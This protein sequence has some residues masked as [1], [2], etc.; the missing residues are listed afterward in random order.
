[1]DGPLDRFSIPE[2]VT[3]IT[4]LAGHLNAGN[5]HFLA[6]IAELDRRR[7]W[8]EWGVKSCAHWLNWKCG[9]NLGAAREKLRAAHALEQLPKI[10]AAMASGRI[11]YAKVRAMTRTAD[12]S[13]E[14]YLLSIALHGTAQHVERTVRSYR[15]AKESQEH[16][17]EA[18]QHL[19]QNL[20][21]FTQPDGSILIRGRVPAEIGE[22]LRRALQLAE[23]S[24]PIPKNVSAETF[25]EEDRRRRARRPVEAL[26][27][28]AESFLAH[29]PQDV[30]G[31]DRQQIVIHVDAQTLKHDHEGRCEFEHGPSMAAETA[32]R[33]ACDASLITMIEN[34]EGE[35]LNVGRK[36]RTIPPGIRRALNS[37]DK[38]C[39]FPGCTFQRYVD[40][41]HIKHWVH[42]GETKLSNLVMLCRFHHRLVHEG[43]VEVQMLDDGAVRF[44][45]PGGIAYDS[46]LPG[47]TRHATVA[48]LMAAN[49]AR[50]I[51]I[52]RRTA[53]PYMTDTGMDY[54][55]AVD[56]LLS[57]NARQ[58]NVSAET[59]AGNPG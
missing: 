28:L 53:I 34:E 30:S 25:S 24:L 39:R 58:K 37:R 31:A 26:G 57:R 38:D 48:K 20:W 41:H 5:A 1:M 4:E 22:L 27:L 16:S 33:P 9:L 12:L 13:N 7:G 59:C 36:T 43:K 19:N 15:R 49:E 32:R 29:G 6:L 8:A 23:D 45:R 2:L 40:G 11:S 50:G 42:G 47:E 55:L 52:T 44:V 56:L 14:D 51:E 35:P 46:P 21:L 18:Q 54:G 17:R 10:R 3:E